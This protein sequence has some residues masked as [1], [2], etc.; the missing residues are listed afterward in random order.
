[1]TKKTR[2]NKFDDVTSNIDSARESTR[3]MVQAVSVY[4]H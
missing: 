1:M 3:R 2:T 4:N